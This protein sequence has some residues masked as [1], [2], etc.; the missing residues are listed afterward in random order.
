MGRGERIPETRQKK[1]KKI[2]HRRISVIR[3]L[4]LFDIFA[5]IANEKA[6]TRK[7]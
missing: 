1:G 4:F 2:D 7:L 6:K 5:E 3:M